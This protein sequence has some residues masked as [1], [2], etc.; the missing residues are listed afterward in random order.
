MGGEKK[1]FLFLS[2]LVVV[3]ITVM[4]SL[5]FVS[6]WPYRVEVGVSLLLLLALL[7]GVFVRGRLV[8]QQLRQVRYR[9]YEETP[10]D[11]YGEPYYWH[12]GMQENPYRAP[13]Q[14]WQMYRS[15]EWE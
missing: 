6:L 5:L 8:E 13:G 3:G 14:T 10:L 11:V 2:M 12:P 15:Q 1:A 4:Y 7:V 9:H